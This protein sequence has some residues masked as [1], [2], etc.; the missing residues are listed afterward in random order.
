MVAR[1]SERRWR[2]IQAGLTLSWVL[3]IASLFWPDS[4]RFTD[5]NDPLAL[6]GWTAKSSADGTQA[7]AYPL[8][9]RLW[10]SIAIP[11]LIVTVLVF[12][13]DTWRRICPL[14]F[15]SQIPR[16]LGFSRT[17]RDAGGARVPVLVRADSWWAR[18]ALMIQF[19]LLWFG[20][21]LRLVITNSNPIALAVFLGV[22]IFAALVVGFLYGGKTWCH[23]VCP[24]A[25]V[26]YT[27]AGPGGLLT[28]PA[29]QSAGKPSQSMCR[30]SSPSGD[31]STCV[32]CNAPC[33]DIDLERHYWERN[34]VATRRAVVYG[35]LGLVIGFL[36]Q[37]NLQGGDDYNLSAFWYDQSDWQRLNSSGWHFAGHALPVPRWLAAPVMLALVSGIFMAV[38]LW[39]E[40]TVTRYSGLSTETVRHRLMI[41]SAVL[42]LSILLW[43]RLI[44]GFSVFPGLARALLVAAVIGALAIWAYRSWQRTR[45]AWHRESMAVS[46]RR[47]VAQLPIDLNV[48]LNGRR[49]EELN[50]DEVHLLAQVATALDQGNRQQLYRGVLDDLV[51][52]AQHRGPTAEALLAGLRRQLGI[53]DDEHRSA[54]ILINDQVASDPRLRDF[55]S[56][57][58][59]L[60]VRHLA[61]GH[62]LAESLSSERDALQEAQERHG[63]SNQEVEQITTQMAAGDGMLGQAA[64]RLAEQ[65]AQVWSDAAAFSGDNQPFPAYIRHCLSERGQG[66]CAQLIA[67]L[68][69][70]GD[71]QA[72]VNAAN[73]AACAVPWAPLAWRERL[74]PG[75]VNALEKPSLITVSER[76][77]LLQRLL[78]DEDP[79]VAL[80]AARCGNVTDRSLIAALHHHP[81]MPEFLRPLREHKNEWFISI[82]IDGGAS[83]ILDRLPATI[84]REHTNDVP[85]RHAMVSRRH[86]ILSVEN[87]QVFLQELGSANG[88]LVDGRW[89]RDRKIHLTDHCSIVLGGHGGPQLTVSKQQGQTDD[90]LELLARL[91]LS[92]L[93]AALP[94]AA[95]RALAAACR[96][97]TFAVGSSVL[98]LGQ[99]VDCVRVVLQGTARVSNAAGTTIGRIAPGETIGELAL[100]VGGPASAQV[101]AET[102]LL[103]AT[104]PAESFRNLLAHQPGMA[105]TLLAQV[106]RRLVETLQQNNSHNDLEKTLISS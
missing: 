11:A 24:M 19:T 94:S 105:Q 69:A 92:T 57:L 45:S 66:L 22:V 44:A 36:L 10:W 79:V 29:A 85:I 7:Q 95:N 67:V 41:V 25:P 65:V 102:T 15:F 61:Q 12:G 14:S 75:V 40:K 39:C 98:A 5:P 80:M 99:T 26:Q 100:V 74:A 82:S 32:A 49:L 6:S 81:R 86:A 43:T 31:V 83:R 55:R 71:Q 68:E 91:A 37:Q 87:N 56:E 96:R 27:Y 38:G 72:A 90:P 33:P 63:L 34:E 17:R 53:S 93:C 52:H 50:T 101:R 18:H 106:G 42:A 47:R 16:R 70:L 21:S 35:Y 8:G 104:L 9:L 54:L 64:V 73:Q 2:I 3:V 1:W 30:Q 84:G 60:L 76:G 89:I 20:L 78:N 58:E 103:C 88:V 23:Y 77:A 62:S 46:L 51:A 28:L 97:E 4:Y 59:R 13:H 48:H